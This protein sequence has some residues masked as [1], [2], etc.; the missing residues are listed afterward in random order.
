MADKDI[1]KMSIKELK[2]L[3]VIQKAID[4]SITQK[5]AASMIGLSER[6]FRR[7]LKSVREQ[8]D[9]GIIHK[10]RGRPSN[11][12]LPEKTRAKVIKLYKKKYHD[13]GPTL[14]SEKLEEL[15]GIK[16]SNES[17]RAWLLDAGLWKKKRKRSACRQWR[18]RKECFGQM[19]QMDGSHH[20]W[21]EGRGPELVFMGYIDD[22]NNN[23]YGRFYD[24]EGTFPAMDSLKRYVRKY[25]LP[26]SIYVDK[27]ST[28]QSKK[29]L[30]AEEE[31]EGVQKPM[32][33]FERALDELGVEVIHANSPQA[34]GRIE[35]LFGTLQDR[36]VKEMRLK[37][38][39]TKEEAN[40]FLKEY[41]PKYNRRF[42]VEAANSTD[43]HVK[44][45]RSF[46]LDKYLCIKTTR[47]VRSD[48][49]VACNGKLYQIK[50][51]ISVGK[52]TLQERVNGS[53]H[54]MAEDKSLKYR[55]ITERPKKE[56]EA[57]RPRSKRKPYVPAMDHPWRRYQNPN[58]RPK[59]EGVLVLTE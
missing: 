30:A 46:K 57:R 3:K 27:H 41:L 9:M 13:F 1:I 51:K 37:W 58:P 26:I 12:R 54:I 32:S 43:A 8:G 21:L 42:K 59:I 53:L 23:V 38:I 50:E 49:T 33:Q 39:K 34:K 35:R 48:N 7:I 18:Q 28:Y 14:A 2:R 55:E 40:S 5:L 6:Q 22:A 10:S 25:G 47:T 16:I 45:P 29:R 15:D 56:T 11:R 4:R 20:D 36:L 17:L 52:V 44:L 24:Y 19:V 31:L